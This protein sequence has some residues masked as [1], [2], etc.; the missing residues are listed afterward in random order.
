[1]VLVHSIFSL[2]CVTTFPF[3]FEKN[4]GFL[5]LVWMG[6]VQ[7]LYFNMSE[8]ILFGHSSQQ[9]ACLACL[10]VSRAT[11]KRSL[12][13]GML[14]LNELFEMYRMHLERPHRAYKEL[15]IQC[16]ICSTPDLHRQV[17]P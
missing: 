2:Q 15:C 5:R 8:V 17:S 9:M 11:S 10:S 6:E 16:C 12:S 1:L 7:L 3:F 4:I 14:K 13:F